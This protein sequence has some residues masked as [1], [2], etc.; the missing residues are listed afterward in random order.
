MS[1][2]RNHGLIRDGYFPRAN[3]VQKG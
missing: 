2:H 3:D 1:N